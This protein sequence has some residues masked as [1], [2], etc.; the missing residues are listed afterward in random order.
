MAPELLFEAPYSFES[1]IWSLGATLC[2]LILGDFPTLHMTF[3]NGKPGD[4]GKVVRESRIHEELKKIDDEKL[5]L[6]LEYMIKEN[7]KDRI[8]ARGALHLLFGTKLEYPEC[9]SWSGYDESDM[10]GYAVVSRNSRI[11]KQMR[12]CKNNFTLEKYFAEI[13]K[14]VRDREVSIRAVAASVC[15]FSRQQMDSEIEEACF[16]A[17]L[18]MCSNFY[19][20]E[21]VTIMELKY[22]TKNFSFEKVWRFIQVVRTD[23]FD[24]TDPL[25]ALYIFMREQEKFASGQQTMEFVRRMIFDDKMVGKSSIEMARQFLASK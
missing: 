10:K 1:D 15:L 21:A 19:D 5:C 2:D 16:F 17:C 11:S 4:T 24:L 7:P 12:L 18:W 8:T 25:E 3:K 6:V 23:F 20:S 13:K 14:M 22:H 9:I